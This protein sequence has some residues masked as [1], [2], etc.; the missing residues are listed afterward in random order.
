MAVSAFNEPAATDHPGTANMIG[1]IGTLMANACSLVHAI[2][3][4]YQGHK[5]DNDF[6]S[7]SFGNFEF[8]I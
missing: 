7:E 5:F 3:Y 6:G 1:S 2:L 4:E 8:C